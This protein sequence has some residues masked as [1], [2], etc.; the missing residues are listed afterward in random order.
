MYKINYKHLYTFNVIYLSDT[1]AENVRQGK[2]LGAIMSTES[3]RVTVRIPKDKVTALQT[4]VD[5]G[6]YSTISD[7]VRAAIDAFVDTHF[8]P[9]HITRMT[10]EL[11]K[12]NV[13]KLEELVHDGDAISVDDAVRNAVRD[14][15]RMRL[16]RTLEQEQEDQE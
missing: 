16:K 6:Q 12:G 5:S 2:Y 3:E 1:N 15:V 11:P 13:V 9:E 8:T 14:Y 4:M 10:V 7:V